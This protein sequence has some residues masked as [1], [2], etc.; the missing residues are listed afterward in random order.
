MSNR[1]LGK[2]NPMQIRTSR[3]TH[4]LLA[5]LLAAALWPASA[6]P[7]NKHARSRIT[8]P[9]KFA[10]ISDPHLY[11]ARLGTSGAAWQQTLY[12]DPKLLKESQAILESALAGIVRQNVKFL[13]I[14]GDLTK[15][16]ELV[17]HVLMT[18]YLQKL[19]Q[20]GIQTFV[21]PGN[22]DINNPYAV[23]YMG[24]TTRPVPGVSPNMFMALYQRFGYGQALSHD[25]NSLSYVAEP[26]PGLW[27]LAIDSC[28]YDQNKARGTPVIGG[29]ISPETIRWIVAQMQQARASGKQVIAFMHHGINLHFFGED[30]LFPE[31]LVDDWHKVSQQLAAAGL[32][33][34]FTG[35]Y[36]SQD[37]AYPAYANG[38]P[39]PTLCDVE[40]GSLAQYPCAFR[41]VTL[42]DGSLNIQSQRVTEADVDTGGLPFQEF[43]EQNLRGLMQVQIDQEL[44]TLFG[45]GPAEI[46]FVAPLVTD[47]LVA[48]YAGDETISPE[49]AGLIDY[50]MGGGPPMDQLGMLLLGLW[51]DLYPGD[52]DLAIPVDTSNLGRP[53]G[54]APPPPLPPF[55]SSGRAGPLPSAPA[56]APPLLA[57]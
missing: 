39:I 52:N 56:G 14:S 2:E 30:Q 3:T 33:V 48:N 38:Q 26:V 23:R 36:H 7:P 25:A 8:E 34:V 16:G 17:D 42:Q 12:H 31:Y 18:Q 11:N 37:A 29:K 22:H 45:L 6:G 19:R 13:I 10:V 44:S 55:G 46:A 41:V 21:V 32:G 1:N 20:Q 28:K 4:L 15:D 27:L 35:H 24:D 51:T 50:L 53:G 47:A 57:E 43:A 54:V 49:T 40:T 5:C 9:V